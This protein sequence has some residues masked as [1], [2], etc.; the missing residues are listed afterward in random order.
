VV[1]IRPPVVQGLQTLRVS[2]FFGAQCELFMATAA[3]AVLIMF[4]T[5]LLTYPNMMP[6][7]E[8]SGEDGL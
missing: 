6:G 2:C 8:R 1:V 5:A 3:R 7:T 4:A